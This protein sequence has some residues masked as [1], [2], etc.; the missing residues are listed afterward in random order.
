MK[1]EIKVPTTY[2]TRTHFL[3][4]GSLKTIFTRTW[5]LLLGRE[6][7]DSCG[8]SDTAQEKRNDEYSRILLI[9]CCGVVCVLR[10]IVVHNEGWQTFPI[11]YAPWN[12]IGGSSHSI[13]TFWLNPKLS[14]VSSM[15]C[16]IPSII[17]E[18]TAPSRMATPD[19]QMAHSASEANRHLI[20][21]P[22]TCALFSIQSCI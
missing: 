13:N 9:T 19:K 11:W 18:A 12:I 3:R 5:Y 2:T 22:T 10:A 1:E 20:K 6:S 7:C 21:R 16:V 4:K 14:K 8:K 15:F 17:P